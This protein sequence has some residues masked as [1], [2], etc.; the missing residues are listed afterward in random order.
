[1]TRATSLPADARIGRVALLAADRTELVE[2]YRDVVGLEVH[3]R[4]AETTT[5]GAGDRTL[6]AVDEAQA[7]SPRHQTETGLYHTAFR[8]PSRE[9]LGGALERIRAQWTLD[10]ASDHDVS[11]ALYLSDPA[12]NG[13]E[14]YCDRPRDQWQTNDGMVQMG[15]SPLDLEGLKAVADDTDSIDPETTV[16]HVHLEVSDIEDARKFYERTIGFDVTVDLEPSALFL[17][18]GGYHHHVGL[19][20]WNNRS[21]PASG[22]GLA[23]FEILLPEE[24]AISALRERVESAD[25]SVTDLECGFEVT[26][27][28]EIAIRVRLEGRND[29]S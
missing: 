20:T 29:E 17:A 3:S 4:G 18:A 27:P 25:Y 1:M 11:E 9:A 2:F 13:V 12:G 8:V 15:T 19:N 26:D 14:I 22:S 6:L 10:G 21:A 23:W 28:D 5:L 24:A 16:G 7:A